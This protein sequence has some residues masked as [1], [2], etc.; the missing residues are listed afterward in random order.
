M[1]DGEGYPKAFTMVGN[2]RMEYSNARI[3]NDKLVAYV[4][5]IED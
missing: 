4:E 3:I 1:L 2:G 5:Y